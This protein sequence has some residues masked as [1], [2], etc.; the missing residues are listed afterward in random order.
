[1]AEKRTIENCKE[2]LKKIKAH[3]HP[4]NLKVNNVYHIPPVITLDRMDIMI[5]GMEGDYIRFKRV[6]SSTDTAE[7]KM[8]KTCI[9]S[10][11]I[12]N[13]RKF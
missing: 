7:K 11:F 4:S 2:E 9:L 12:V 8:H 10:R 5:L 6:D 3:I 13:K 1:M